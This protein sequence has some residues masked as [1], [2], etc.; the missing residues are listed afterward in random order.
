MKVLLDECLPK[1]FCKSLPEHE[2]HTARRAGFGGKTNGDLLTAAELAGFNVLITVDKSIPYQQSL[3]ARKLAVVILWAL[4]NDLEDLLPL[5]TAC[6]R[7]LRSIKPGQ[8]LRIPP[9]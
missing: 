3:A 7:A 5:A 2:C 4:S 9:D 6:I 8:V 1:D